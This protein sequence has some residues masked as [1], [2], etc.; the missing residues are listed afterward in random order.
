MDI[1]TNTEI[2]V[3]LAPKNH[4]AVYSQNLPMPINLKEDLIVELPLML[5]HEIITVLL[6]AKYPSSIFAQK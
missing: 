2:I 4:K 3:K 6:F 5:K 1:G